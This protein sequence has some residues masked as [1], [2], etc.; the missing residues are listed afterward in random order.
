MNELERIIDLH[1]DIKHD[2]SKWGLISDI[3][4]YINSKYNLKSESVLKVDILAARLEQMDSHI[5]RLGLLRAWAVNHQP[6]FD[7]GERMATF[8]IAEIDNEI[9]I[10]KKWQDELRR[11]IK[12]TLNLTTEEK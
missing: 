9:K 10:I 7:S 8:T 2:G 3:E 4:A 6:V 11:Q 5:G 1:I 12:D